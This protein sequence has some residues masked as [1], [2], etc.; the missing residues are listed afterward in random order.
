MYI[1]TYT[2]Y[3]YKHQLPTYFCCLYVF[4]PIYTTSFKYQVFQITHIISSI[5]NVILGTQG[6][7]S[8]ES[9]THPL[10]EW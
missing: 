5:Y 9:L 6:V 3:I 7:D 10:A 1:H 4:A 2:E 8:A